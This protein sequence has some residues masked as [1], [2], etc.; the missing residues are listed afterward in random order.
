MKKFAILINPGHNRVYFE[1]SKRLALGELEIVGKKLSAQL[2]EISLQTICSVAYVVFKVKDLNEKDKQILSHLS[3]FYA[4]FEMRD[5][6]LFPQNAEGSFFID[7]GISALLKYTGK[8]NESFTRMLINLA[9]YSGNFENGK[10]KLLDPLAGKGTT[11]FEG[12]VCGY[13]VS[14]IEIGPKVVAE[15]HTFFKK[16][17]EREKFKHTITDEKISGA[18]KSFAGRK[19]SFSFAKTKEDFKDNLAKRLEIVCGNSLYADK[20]F[21]KNSFDVI[22]ADLPYGIQH[23]NVTNEKQS[24]QTRNPKELLKSCLP[25]WTEL[26][27]CGG[28]I[29]LSWNSFLL[30]REDVCA[31]VKQKGLFVFDDVI[32]ASFEHRVDNAI[33]RDL[34]VAQKTQ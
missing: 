16:Y 32:Y 11:L 22:V 27:K 14:G 26:L 23:G 18:N 24:S 8:T 28:T 12:L 34:I 1:S 4:L 13:D 29:A 30:S 21:K 19:I 10:I 17:L 31:L 25:V 2:N 9:V 33:K 3:F 20:F 6:G 5:E 7:P 15:V